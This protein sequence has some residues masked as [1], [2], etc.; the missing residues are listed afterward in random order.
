M[1]RARILSVIEGQNCLYVKLDKYSHID[2]NKLMQ[3]I[4][5]KDSKIKFDLNNFNQLII[6]DIEDAENVIEYIKIVSDETDFLISDSSERNFTVRKEKE[7]L[8]NLKELKNVT[9]II[10][11]HKMAALEICNKK[12][13]IKDGKIISEG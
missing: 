10:V 6:S 9:C 1:K 7:F 12:I 5:S 8:Q 4:N 3:L 11:S 2:T 13:Q